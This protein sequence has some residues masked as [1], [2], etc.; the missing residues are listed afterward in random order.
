MNENPRLTVIRA[1]IAALERDGTLNDSGTTGDLRWLL[2]EYDRLK[3]QNR[4]NAQT[5]I[6]QAN[7]LRRQ[8]GDLT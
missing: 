2:A 1:N 3:E 5:V 4:L 6:R 7:D 8:M